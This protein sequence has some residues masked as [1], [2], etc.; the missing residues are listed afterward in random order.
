MTTESLLLKYFPYKTWRRFQREIAYT[1]YDGLSQGDVV[2]IEAPTGIGKTSAI[3]AGALAYAEETDYKILYLIRTK[4]EAQ[5]PLRELQRLRKKNV[6]VPYVVIRSRLDMC[7]HAESKKMPYEEFVEE[8]KYL[9]STGKCQ[10]YISAQR[11]DMDLYITKLLESDLSPTEIVEDFCR[12]GVCP[13]EISKRMLDK[14]RLA[15][16]TYH[17]V[18][19]VAL[20]ETFDI[21][22]SKTVLVIDEAHNLPQIIIDANSFTISELTIRAC[23]NEVKKYISNEDLKNEVLKFLKDILSYMR[24][25]KESRSLEDIEKSYIQVDVSEVLS[26]FDNINVVKDAYIE[27]IS[28]KRSQ[29]AA[30][31]FSY[32]GRVL[33]FHR[34]LTSIGSQFAIFVSSNEGILE[35][36]CRCLDPAIISSRIFSKVAGAVLMSGTLP[37]TDYVKTML[38]IERYTRELRI[39]FR[40]YVSQGRIRAV[41][42]PGITTRYVERTETMFEKIGTLLSS[43]YDVFVCRKA[44]LAVFP[45]YSVLKAVRRY[46]RNDV[47]YIMELSS[48]SV[49]S[50]LEKLR[51]NPRTLIMAVAG[52]KLME[53]VEFKLNGENILGMVVIVGVPYPEPNDFLNMFKDI[54]STR[55]GSSDYAWELVYLW[56]ALIK[57]KQAIGRA[58]RSEKDIA[59]VLLMDRRFLDLRVRKSVE[60]YLG[61]IEVIQDEDKLLEDIENFAK[62][63]FA[64]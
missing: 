30:L 55:I 25:I 12:E 1:V 5:A 34:R 29:G 48:T 40:E 4:S 36:V 57:I 22:L 15:I 37:P 31:P 32:L 11:V 59:Y 63:N 52:G 39:P 7:C 42:Y 61:T 35:I 49:E 2:L 62:T 54:V 51:E 20:S 47:S 33:E 27:I 23:I 13:Y 45:S 6:Y 21:D 58:I 10:Y 56:N 28:K 16:M 26:L 18:F 60:D 44:I 64:V 46:L 38:G 41:V 24:R 9:R 19:S 53:G 43:I 17:Y 3:L 14:A 8:C 50:V